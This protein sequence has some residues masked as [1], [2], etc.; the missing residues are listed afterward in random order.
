MHLE[1]YKLL[2]SK[3]SFD[4]YFT[5]VGPNGS[6]KKLI[7]YTAITTAGNIL[8]YNLAFGDWNEEKHQI[9][10]TSISNNQDRDKILATVA[11]SAYYFTDRH[12]HA[13]IFAQGVDA[14]RTRLYQMGIGT[15]WEEISTLFSL[16]GYLENKGWHAF[17]K[18]INY[19]A[20]L[21]TRR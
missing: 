6:I 5:S 10:D 1:Q 18:G 13:H 17:Q 7:R 16:W 3:D 4:Y 19:V 11:A 9:E 2:A 20:F 15:H 12:P 8:L 14:A 21:T